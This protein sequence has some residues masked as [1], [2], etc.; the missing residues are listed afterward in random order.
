[1]SEPFWITTTLEKMS[2]AQWES[3]CD[4]CGKCC[5]HKLEDEDT[6]QLFYTSAVCR[7][8]DQDSCA[9]TE[10]MER[11]SLVPECVVL[12][13]DNLAEIYYMPS[14]CAYRLLAEGKA[15]PDW[16]HLICGDKKTIHD[17]GHSVVGKVV[18]EEYIHPDELE[19]RIVRWVK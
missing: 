4:H 13:P 10:Y 3:L 14:T 1:M 19:E 5:L 2:K 17:T 16:H 15:L 9:C 6:G 8:I 7:Y 11:S 18:S 12:S